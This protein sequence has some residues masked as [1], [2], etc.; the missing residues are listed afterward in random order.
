M[1]DMVTVILHVEDDLVLRGLVELA[2]Q[3][4]G[5]R[6]TVISAG[7]VSEAVE[8]L[9]AAEKSGAGM[10]LIVSDMNLPDGS[11]LDVVRHVRA[12]ST[13]TFTPVLILS[14]DVNPR[15]VGRAYALG[16]NAYLDKSPRGR[17]LTEV[18]KSLYNHWGKDAVLPSEQPLDSVQQLFAVA[19]AIRRRHA[20]LYQRLA[21]KFGDS[22]SESAFW[23]S[24]AL[25]ESNLVNL[26]E[27]LRRHV[28]DR[29]LP[30][31]LPEEV[32]RMQ[33]DVARVLGAAEQAV[34][35]ESITRAEAYR[36]LL[37]LVA[38][39]DVDAVSRVIGHLFPVAPTATAALRDLFVAKVEDITTWVDLHATDQ[40]L[41]ER[42]VKLRAT[43]APSLAE[44]TAHAPP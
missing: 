2:F 35:D 7:S 20:Q 1:A 29:V 13:W 36:L 33:A 25:A 37:D 14:G 40:E 3:G 41:H 42:A 43:M 15:S 18:I 26:F 10:D 34:A 28:D 32:E 27:F 5:F 6:G 22:R 11:G 21:E 24:R 31:S 19:I 9:D 16:A 23:L 4:F 30:E 8:R 38:A 17:T 12:S 44:L 39:L